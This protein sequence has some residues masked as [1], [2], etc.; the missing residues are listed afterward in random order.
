MS[1]PL[2]QRVVGPSPHITSPETGQKIMLWV[3]AALLPSALWAAISMGA[4]AIIT[5]VSCIGAALG[6][7]AAWN[8]IARKPQTVLDGSALVTGLL[9]A[10]TMPPR[11]PWWISVAAGIVAIGLGKMIFGGLGWN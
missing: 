6:T 3:V 11:T 8:A 4:P 5:L 9:L 7:E 1:E 2:V 10:M